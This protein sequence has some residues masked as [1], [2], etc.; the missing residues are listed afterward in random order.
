MAL[1]VNIGKTSDDTIVLEKSVTWIMDGSSAKNYS[2][3]PTDNC[4]ILLPGLI[5]GY[6]SD[7]VKCNYA[8]ISD[9]GRYYFFRDPQ[10][11]T[12]G[13]M[14]LQLSVDVLNSWPGIIKNS[15]GVITRA[16]LS[17]PTMIPDSQYPLLTGEGIIQNA[18]FSN[19]N[20]YFTNPADSSFVL[21]TLGGDY[22]PP[23]P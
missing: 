4:D 16:S 18:V 13:R 5:L 6:N 23:T 7:I 19:P 1:T 3:K 2:C 12:G 20:G 21:T 15:P 17:A 11:L 10:L 9:F 14:L 8:Y 22:T